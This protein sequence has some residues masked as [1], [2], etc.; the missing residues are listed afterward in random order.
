MRRAR[1]AY[2]DDAAGEDAG[3]MELRDQRQ[4]PEQE[5]GKAELVEVLQA[6]IRRTPPLL[7]HVFQLRDV[8]QRPMAEVAEIL[9]ISAPAAKSRLLRARA[10]L[11]KR[12]RKHC[13]VLGAATLTM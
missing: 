5:L 13:G 7:R 8:E 4:T 3:L 6:E 1:F 9:G 12:L 10:E 2:T 11:R